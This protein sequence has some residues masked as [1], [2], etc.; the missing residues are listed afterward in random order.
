MNSLLLYPAPEPPVGSF[1]GLAADFDFLDDLPPPPPFSARL[2]ALASFLAALICS[3]PPSAIHFSI[4]ASARFLSSAAFSTHSDL[5]SVLIAFHS[6]PAFLAISPMEKPGLSFLMR[7]RLAFIQIMYE[8]I[9][10]FGCPGSFV[11]FFFRS[12]FSPPPLAFFLSL[13]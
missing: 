6:S 7:S 11:S 5:S 3:A 8:L 1:V 12:F 4:S 10:R 9:A 13:F 2:A